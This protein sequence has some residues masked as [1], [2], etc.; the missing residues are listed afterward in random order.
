MKEHRETAWGIHNYGI[1]VYA[2]ISPTRR[3]AIKAAMSHSLVDL[4][5]MP[6]TKNIK[7][8]CPWYQVVKLSISWKEEK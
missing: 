2:T 5:V 4:E 7:K 6:T 3:G 8:Y 1:L